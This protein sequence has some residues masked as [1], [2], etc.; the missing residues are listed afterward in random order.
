MRRI[1]KGWL[2]SKILNKIPKYMI[3]WDIIETPKLKLLFALKQQN[4]KTF[5]LQS[6]RAMCLSCHGQQ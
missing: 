4:T 2:Q 1:T 6:N 3:R 5:N